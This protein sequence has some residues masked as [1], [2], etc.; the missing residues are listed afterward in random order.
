MSGQEFD[1]D[2]LKEASKGIMEAIDSDGDGEV[3]RAEFIN[4]ASKSG[5]I[6]SLLK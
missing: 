6:A 5:F 1:E 3:T 2:D 4:N